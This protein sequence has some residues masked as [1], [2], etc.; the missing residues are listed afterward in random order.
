MSFDQDNLPER[1]LALLN[2]RAFAV[3][4]TARPDGRLHAALVGFT[5]RADEREAWLVL[6]G[7]GV[8]FRNITAR[9]ASIPATLTQVGD[10]GRWIT[11]EGS[12]A[13]LSGHDALSEAMRR[14]RIR[15]GED[16]ASDETRRAGL[17][18]VKRMYGTG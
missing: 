16:I 17:L 2:D 13:L 4:A 8:K 18:Q 7:S 15:Y 9:G 5:Y 14:Y 12:L 3:L 11:L 6:R 1:T 10:G